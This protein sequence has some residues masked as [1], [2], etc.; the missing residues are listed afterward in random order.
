M[1]LSITFFYLF[2]KTFPYSAS[3]NIWE[4]GNAVDELTVEA[5]EIEDKEDLIKS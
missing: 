5:F 1:L 3:S 4:G 2:Y